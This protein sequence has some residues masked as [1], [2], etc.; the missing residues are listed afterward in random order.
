MKHLLLVFLFMFSTAFGQVHI[1]NLAFQETEALEREPMTLAQAQTLERELEVYVHEYMMELEML[2][3]R[4]RHMVFVLDQI[5]PDTV[6][7]VK[8]WQTG[9][10]WVVIFTYQYDYINI[11]TPRGKRV[12]TA[13]EVGH[14]TG[15]CVMFN[16]LE[17]KEICADMMS[18]DLT[19]A[20]EV[21]ALLRYFYRQWPGDPTM[22]GRIKVMENMIRLEGLQE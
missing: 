16:T 1:E 2:T 11:L 4:V 6:A 14:L 19:S 5:E 18:A 8:F 3:P 10:Q 15:K 22:P 7:L 17:L 12:I 13:H 21:L 9:Y 20:E